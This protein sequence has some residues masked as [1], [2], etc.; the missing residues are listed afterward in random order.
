MQKKEAKY[1]FWVD[2]I[3]K[4]VVEREKRLKRGIKVIRTESGIG[5]SGIPHIGSMS[6]SVR[7]FA[8]KLGVEDLG[9]KSEYI[10]YSDSRDGLRKVPSGLPDW[11]EEHIGEPVTNIPDPFGDCHKSYGDH[12]SSLLIDALEKADLKFTFISGA[13]AYKKGL[14]NEQIQKILSNADKLG[15]IVRKHTG[16][17]KYTEVLPYFPLCENCKK[18]YTTRAY[19]LLAGEHKVAYKCDAEF[20]GQN[21]NNNKEILI[22]GCGH[23]GEASYFDGDGKLSWKGEFAARWD[24]LKIC[25]EAFGKDIADSV[26]V[27]DAICKEILGFEPPVHIMYEMFLDKGGKKISKSVGN[28]F[29]PQVWMNYGTPESLVLLMLKRFEGTRELDVSDIPRYM[30]EVNKLMLTYFGKEKVENERDLINM[31]RLFAYINFLKPPKNQKLHIPYSVMVEVAKVLPERNQVEFAVGK[32][33]ESGHIKKSGKSDEKY[34]EMLLNFAKNWVEDF[35]RTEA[36]EVQ[37]SKGEKTAIMELIDMIRVEDRPEILQ[38]KIFG[39]GNKHKIKSKRFF[40]ILYNIL[41][42]S[43]RGPRLGAYIHQVGKAEIISK[44][45]DFV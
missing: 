10:A 14:L 29:T 31:K 4:E 17:E 26:R 2:T 22:K 27:N 28:V 45:K 7:S 15:D 21:K 1:Q 5:A 35:E 20:K 3:A 11:L 44:L 23:E 24:A 18:I 33:K 6:D 34:I 13:E 32:L 19:K 39:I 12:M 30:D 43:D 40:Q 25:F 9:K 37:L 36:K 42:K 8:V 41:L 16:Q 38:E